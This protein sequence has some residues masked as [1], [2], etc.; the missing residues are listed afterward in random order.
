VFILLVPASIHAQTAGPHQN[1]RAMTQN[2]YLGADLSPL[3]TAGDPAAIFAA[4]ASIWTDVQETDIPAR[5]AKIADK[6]AS[7]KPDLVGLQE[8]EQ[9]W[10]GPT[11]DSLAVQ[12]DF[13]QSILDELALRGAHYTAAG[14]VNNTDVTVPLGQF[15]PFVRLVDRGAL[16]VRTDLP[17]LS[18]PTSGVHTGNFAHF[19]PIMTPLGE[20]DILRGWI[21]ADVTIRGNTFRFITTQLES[22]NAQVQEAQALELISGSGP[23]ANNALPVV[24]AG[25]FNSNANGQSG[26]PDNTATYG[27]LL[28]AGFNDLWTE[29]FRNKIG[30]TCCQAADLI[31]PSQLTERL[32]LFLVNDKIGPAAVSDVGGHNGDRVSTPDGLLWPSDHDGVITMLK[33]F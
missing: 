24:M 31:G 11:P 27:D 28:A 14:F 26:L 9:W 10:F 4:A 25:D 12:F 8:A 29:V 16:L 2:L 6:I 33:V 22:F 32:D 7:A 21:S 3:F 5:A 18:V 13:L 17:F 30:N 15:G 1:M 20:V 23:A 19:I